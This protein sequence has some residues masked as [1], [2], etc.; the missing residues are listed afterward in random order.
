MAQD[1]KKAADRR[2]LELEYYDVPTLVFHWLT[3]AFVLV[4]MGTSLVW[5]YWTP[6][7]RYWRPLMEG[8]HVSWGILFA[9]L[10]LTRVAWR[11]ASGRHVPAEAGISGVLSRV[12]YLILYVLLM[13]E[14]PLGVLLRW[15]QGEG[16]QF[17][18][19][20]SVPT[21]LGPDK[22]L[23][24]QF[25]DL[26]NWVSW[27]IIILA[28]VHATAALVHHYVLKDQVMGRMLCRQGRPVQ[29]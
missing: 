22:V 9:V 11:L 19:L 21:L 2:V 26:H 24:R 28:I 3:V 27:T 23:A 10:I 5:N 4:L 12:M 25:E 8:T 17:F 1:I 14:I 15:F 16:S 29:S 7:D 18:G 20:F 13:S 6:H